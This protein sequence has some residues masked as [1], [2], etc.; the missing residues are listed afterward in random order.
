[1]PE[2]GRLYP[3]GFWDKYVPVSGRQVK[4]IT[5]NDEAVSLTLELDLELP[6]GRDYTFAFLGEESIIATGR[7]LR[8]AGVE[9]RGELTCV[10][11]RVE[12]NHCS[13]IVRN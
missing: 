4:A 1:M 7:G 8:V 10:D 3:L 11:F 2:I 5:V 9:K 12:A 6:T 13:L